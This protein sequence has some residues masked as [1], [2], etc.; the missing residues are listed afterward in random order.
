VLS[1][2]TP[3]PRQPQLLRDGRGRIHLAWLSRQDDVQRLYQRVLYPADQAA[4]SVLLSQEDE[5]VT[6]YTMYRTAG[7]DVALLWASERAPGERA[8]VQVRLD[9][10]AER[11]TLVQDGTDPF[12][13]VDRAGTVHVAWLRHRGLTAYDVV[14]A[15]LADSDS[16]A[17]LVPAGGLKLT[18]FETSEGALTYG[19]F[20]GLDTETVYVLWAD[21]NVG[22][23]LT[24][25]SA[26]AHYVAFP[27]G[28]PT[29]KHAV[30]IGLPSTMR[31]D[32]EAY[33]GPYGLTQ[34]EPL[35]PTG[36]TAG[37]DYVSAPAVA[38]TQLGTL[39]VA[40][41]LMTESEAT[42]EIQI[43]TAIFAAGEPVGYQLASKTSNASLVPSLAVDAQDH[44]HL[45]WID[46]AGFANYDV[47]YAST[48]PAARRWLDRT[49][50]EDLV[51][52]AARVLFG[53]LSGVGL[54]PIA[55]IWSFPA[56]VWVVLFFIFTGQEDMDR[57]AT[58]IGFAVAVLVYVGMK[59][60]LLPGL[61]ASTPL[62]QQ[63]PTRWE[64]PLGIAVPVLILA[65]AL[66]VVYLYARR[67][68][69]ATIF[70]A[71]LIL[72]GV[73]VTLTLVLYA[74]GFFGGI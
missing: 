74:P 69:R 11:A 15:T 17:Q 24:P 67:A 5:D 65:V 58:R 2:E 7:G 44:L 36:T 71:I 63:V 42:R 51:H 28:S 54:L 39:A 9:A 30:T 6:S 50:T 53:V 32:Y 3:L 23:G 12:A 1:I 62:L 48:A 27:I 52:G 34:L 14:Y 35:L 21:Q 45:A 33:Q 25:T 40:F 56:V 18:D 13:V 38:P 8:L 66:L 43:A 26:F 4:P 19:P 68:E 55:G 57:A 16:G 72:V 70:K 37:S 10:P 47:Y 49:T 73:D 22:G 64:V 31:P 59:I 46:T 20:I 29:P 41:S 60:L 61:F